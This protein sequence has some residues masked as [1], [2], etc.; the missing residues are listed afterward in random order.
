MRP[1]G[2]SSSAVA[3]EQ[4]SRRLVPALVFGDRGMVTLAAR[5]NLTLRVRR[6]KHPKRCMS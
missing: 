3:P 1:D 5:E 2:A 6:T 4:K